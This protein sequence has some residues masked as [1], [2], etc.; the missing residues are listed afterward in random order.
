RVRVI[1]C[2]QNRGA[3]AALNIGIEAARG[4]YIARLDA[5]DVCEPT[6]LEKQIHFLDRNPS[7]GM[8]G[9]WARYIDAEGEIFATEETPI[10]PEVID[11]TLLH[12]NC[13]V[14]SS[15][16]YR[17]TLVRNAGGYDDRFKYVEDYDLWLRLQEVS[18]LANIAEHLVGYRVHPAQISTAKL[19]SQHQTAV[20]CREAARYRRGLAPSS[21]E[22]GANEED[23][24]SLVSTYLI[25]GLRYA[26]MGE[27]R[28]AFALARNAWQE[29]NNASA[30]LRVARISAEIAI[31]ARF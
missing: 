2:Q 25:W 1:K 19:K 20:R 23:R 29:S 27:R 4:C 21:K 22:I 7:V 16:M 18:S 6:R 30:R 31:G 15:V 24:R 11:R 17:A 9:T 14:N 3:P 26:L 5:D 28:Q 12:A 10:E 13:F 8:V